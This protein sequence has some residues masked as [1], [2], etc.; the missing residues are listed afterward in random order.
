MAVYECAPI[1]R[2]S[3]C[4]ERCESFQVWR[5]SGLYPWRSLDLMANTFNLLGSFHFYA[6][7]K[8]APHRVIFLIADFRG[9]IE[10]S[11]IYISSVF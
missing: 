5:D 9:K 11:L 2:A 6:M 7:E 1:V 10:A 4:R 8:I 3:E